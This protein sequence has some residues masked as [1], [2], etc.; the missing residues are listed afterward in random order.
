MSLEPILEK[1][2]DALLGCQSIKGQAHA[3]NRILWT[4]NT[5]QFTHAMSLWTVG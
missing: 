5:P 1:Q 3:H 2:G 4:I